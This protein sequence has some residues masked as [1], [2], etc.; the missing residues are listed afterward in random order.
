MR[1]TLLLPKKCTAPFPGKGYFA[2][3]PQTTQAKYFALYF[4]FLFIAFILILVLTGSTPGGYAVLSFIA[5]L[6]IAGVF[7][8]YMPRKTKEG[9]LL[10]EKILGLREY[11]SVAEKGR[12]KFH[13][14]PEKNPSEFEKLLPYA[15]VL[16]VEKDWA[17]QFEGILRANPSWYE[18]PRGLD[19]FTA[20]Y[21][22][23]SLGDFSSDFRA[24]AA[25]AASGSSGM[26]GGGF[27]GGGFGGGGGG[28]W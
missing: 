28:S 15:I 1:S 8:Y 23:S 16:G 13:N 19:N 11:L 9:V 14:A 17:R 21:F 25:T 18:D 12:L 20:L 7:A 26:G 6:G 2:G 5:S 27:S 24:T 4:V 22:V 3:N 10:R